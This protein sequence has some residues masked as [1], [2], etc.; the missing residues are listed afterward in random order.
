QSDV[1]AAP[2][3]R[4]ERG[5]ANRIDLA[6]AGIAPFRAQHESHARADRDFDRAARVGGAKGVVD[7]AVPQAAR[8]RLTRGPSGP[9]EDR[10]ERRARVNSE[11]PNDELRVLR[12][13][14]MPSPLCRLRSTR[15][16]LACVTAFARRLDRG[17]HRQP[18][19]PRSLS[20][21]LAFR[22]LRAERAI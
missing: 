19:Y 6:H 11:R 4:L 1:E 15:E 7:V 16:R 20:G 2:L 18:A 8:T 9:D 22:R 21:R 5:H 10:R 14:V 3:A 17:E 12:E 13:S